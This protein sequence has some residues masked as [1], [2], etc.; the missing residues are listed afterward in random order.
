MSTTQRETYRFHRPITG[1]R[2]RGANAA[3]VRS[4]ATAPSKTA[5]VSEPEPAPVPIVD[6]SKI[7]AILAQIS[8][9]VE[10]FSRSQQMQRDEIKA[11]S[12]SLA[13]NIASHIIGQRVEAGDFSVE[14][15][16][17]RAID[18]LSGNQGEISVRLNPEDL[19]TLDEQST[20]A[21]VAQ[22]VQL[23]ADARLPRG[24][25]VAVQGQRQLISSIEQRLDDAERLLKKGMDDAWS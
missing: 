5:P 19:A 2:L 7:E 20:A 24:S 3:S 18:Q 6:T 21:T 8:R 22:Q 10:D 25:C 23:I 9:A 15:L 14:P 4:S 16:L 11:T 12:I 17:D 13:T 1:V